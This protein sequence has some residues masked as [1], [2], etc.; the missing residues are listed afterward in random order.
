LVCHLLI[1]K[2]PPDSSVVRLYN[3]LNGSSQW[4][5]SGLIGAATICGDAGTYFVR[6]IDL[7]SMKVTFQQ[8]FYTNFLY[9]SPTQWF[10]AFE[11][12]SGV[13]GLSFADQQEATRFFSVVITCKTKAQNNIGLASNGSSRNLNQS[14]QTRP[15][16]GPDANN[17][18]ETAAQRKKR[19][20]RERRAQKEKEKQERKIAERERK[21]NG[22][23]KGMVIEGPTNVTHVSHMGWD[24]VN[25]FQLR[26]IPPEWRKLFKDAGVRKTD[27]QN[28]E[29]ALFIMQTVNKAMA[30]GA[31]AP[32]PP[33]LS[34]S[35]GRSPSP[36]G[37][38]LLSRPPIPPPPSS[39][40]V[41]APPPRGSPQNG[42][43]DGFEENSY[44]QSS[45]DH[46]DYDQDSYNQSGYSNDGTDLS[47]YG[48]NG[49]SGSASPTG[50]SNSLLAAIQNKNLKKVDSDEHRP[51]VDE[52]HT[53]GGMDLLT[54]L[55][56]AMAQRR[57]NIKE[58]DA[59]LR[60]D[61]DGGD[62]SDE[63]W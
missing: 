62:W 10:H 50:T 46:N 18:N 52:P 32:P 40:Y 35:P 25:G 44:N 60:D 45:Y 36:G 37:S 27:L 13:V 48:T 12:D 7:N 17:P 16:D 33:P 2:R 56:N 29:T 38:V 20:K 63:D 49:Y 51:E 6:L 9:S 61:D 34:R 54:T 57:V 31:R 59:D 30:S 22:G 43:N 8:E 55:S 42:N 4:Q 5:Y 39:A 14:P 26:N 41:P 1:S 28:P 19:D 47:D 3:A 15:G 11:T 21:E 53:G 58:D 23:R 24:P